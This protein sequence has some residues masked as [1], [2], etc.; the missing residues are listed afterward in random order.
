MDEQLNQTPENTEA[1][2][3]EPYKARPMWQICLAWVGIAVVFGGFL[4]YL[5]QIATGGL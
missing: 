4:L 3:Q 5:Y 1:P 2:K